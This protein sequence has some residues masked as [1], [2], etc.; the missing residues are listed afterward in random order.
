MGAIPRNGSTCAA[1]PSSTQL[2]SKKANGKWCCTLKHRNG[3]SRC[4]RALEGQIVRSG[5]WVGGYI[6]K[7]KG[8]THAFISVSATSPSAPALSLSLLV[9][10]CL[11]MLT[12]ALIFPLLFLFLFLSTPFPSLVCVC[13]CL[14]P[15]L[16]RLVYVRRVHRM[17]RICAC[18]V[19]RTT[20]GMSARRHSQTSKGRQ[21]NNNDG[22]KQTK[23]GDGK[24]EEKQKQKHSNNV[25]GRGGHEQSR[26]NEGGGCVFVR[27]R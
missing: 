21:H 9:G 18:V 11:W 13:V 10:L 19:V 6:N 16:I 26:K 14:S 22:S 12:A 5:Q 17:G 8:G 3:N 25:G 4:T 24:E 2:S 7:E 27:W 23:G 15:R 20:H 1:F